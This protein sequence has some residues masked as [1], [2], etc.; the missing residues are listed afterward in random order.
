MK[1]APPQKGEGLPSPL[2]LAHAVPALFIYQRSFSLLACLLYL[3]SQPRLPVQT[4]LQELS[5]KLERTRQ[6]YQE[7][8]L[9][10]T[11]L[12]QSAKKV[13]RA[14]R[15]LQDQE[16]KANQVGWR[17][18][19]V[20][21]GEAMRASQLLCRHTLSQRASTTCRAPKSR[22]RWIATSCAA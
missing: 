7:L 19:D 3:H 12:I 18:L 5:S 13:Q 8:V 14:E 22:G 17:P 6:A 20:A 10:R 1:G 9:A 15:K 4:R 11:D 21:V 16:A 2:S